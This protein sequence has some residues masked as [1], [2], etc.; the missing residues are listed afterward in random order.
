MKVRFVFLLLLCSLGLHS[1]TDKALLINYVTENKEV[2][3]YNLVETDNQFYIAIKDKADKNNYLFLSMPEE[4]V[5]GY[6]SNN[7]LIVKI[8][9]NKKLLEVTLIDSKDTPSFVR[10]I[11]RARYLEKFTGWNGADKIKS[12]TGATITCN[13]I[14][15]TLQNMLQR[16]NSLEL[17]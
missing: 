7:K 15:S 14:S 1:V 11:K 8:D 13:S 12:V 9:S 17:H 5:R 3:L 4:E 16:I 6:Q 2:D 10:R